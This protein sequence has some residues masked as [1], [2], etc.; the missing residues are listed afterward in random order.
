MGAVAG[1]AYIFS[2]VFTLRGQSPT[3][4]AFTLVFGGLFFAVSGALGG[5]AVGW[6][7]RRWTSAK[8]IEV[9]RD[10]D[11][12]STVFVVVFF[13]AAGLGSLEGY[14]LELHRVPRVVAAN[15]EVVRWAGGSTR[16]PVTDAVI[17]Y[18]SFG[19]GDPPDLAWRDGHVHV[20][21]SDRGATLVVHHGW[22]TVDR[23]PVDRMP[24]RV[25][26]VTGVT[27]SLDGEREWLA[28]LVEGRPIGGR[29]LLLIY[30]PDGSRAHHELLGTRRHTLRAA[31]APG[32]RQDLLVHVDRGVPLRFDTRR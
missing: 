2:R 21:V 14:R 12:I 18:G 19:A 6:C 30:G 3:G 1:V 4:A 15:G 22:T 11:P 25:S 10:S 13:L 16:T 29:E 26:G 8:G 5:G 9:R 27:A 20:A 24:G 7:V 28:L 32:E 23:V 17:L 31:G